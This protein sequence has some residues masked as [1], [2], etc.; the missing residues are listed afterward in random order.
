MDIVKSISVLPGGGKAG[1][2]NLLA[3]DMA[4][5]QCVMGYP[6]HIPKNSLLQV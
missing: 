2:E 5:F 1:L 4:R 6:L 3:L